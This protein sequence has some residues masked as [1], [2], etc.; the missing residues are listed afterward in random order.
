[1]S[2]THVHAHPES[3]TRASHGNNRGKYVLVKRRT[4]VR[5]SPRGGRK[6][7]K[8]KYKE[9]GAES[10]PAGRRELVL[11]ETHKSRRHSRGGKNRDRGSN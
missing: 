11:P 4:E 8:A 10:K 2:S 7:V 1:M 5:E 3:P 9:R 6:E